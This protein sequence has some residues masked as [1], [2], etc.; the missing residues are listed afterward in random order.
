MHIGKDRGNAVVVTGTGTGIDTGNE[1]I[2]QFRDVLGDF[3]IFVGTG[4]TAETCA[5]QMSVADG[6][7]VGS[8]FKQGGVTEA[9]VDP[10]RVRQFMD[11]VTRVRERMEKQ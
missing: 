1:K 3:P 2:R 11:I 6:V 5:A 7:I 4:M 10:N 8:W 9:P